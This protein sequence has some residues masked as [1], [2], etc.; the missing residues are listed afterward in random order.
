MLGPWTLAPYFSFNVLVW[1]GL[2][3]LA[4][5]LT[6]ELLGTHYLTQANFKLVVMLCLS[7]PKVGT[8]GYNIMPGP[9]SLFFAPIILTVG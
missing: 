9:I 1:F 7:P 6:P 5:C 4:Q 8:A 3:I 2:G